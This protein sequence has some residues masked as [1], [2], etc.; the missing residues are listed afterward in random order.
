MAA[1]PEATANADYLTGCQAPEGAAGVDFP[2]KHFLPWLA[3][4][5]G[6][7]F[8][9]PAARPCGPDLLRFPHSG[10]HG[11]LATPAEPVSDSGAAG[12]SYR[13]SPHGALAESNRSAETP[14]APTARP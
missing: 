6:R 3:P 4:R 1:P 14:I 9:A 11:Q 13:Y 7:A 10:G 8:R 2:R 5:C 12:R